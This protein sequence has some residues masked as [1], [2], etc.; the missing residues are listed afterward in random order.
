MILMS[1]ANIIGASRIF[2]VGGR[3][4]MWNMKSKG[5]KIEPCGIPYPVV[6]QFE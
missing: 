5:L 3:S 6:P 1:L 2:I 4:F